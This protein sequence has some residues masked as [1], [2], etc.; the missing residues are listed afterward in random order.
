MKNR[1]FFI[2]LSFLFQSVLFAAPKNIESLSKADAKKLPSDRPSVAIV[3]A[4]GGAKGFAHLPIMEYLDEL[5]I[6]IDMIIGTSI[7]SIVGGFYAAGYSARDIVDEFSSVDWSPIFAD[8][9]RKPYED[10]YGIHGINA[11]PF[12]INMGTDFSLNMGTGLSNGQNVYQL[13]RSLLLKYPTDISFDNLPIPF[14]A[15]ATDMLTGEAYVLQDGDIADAMRASMSLPAVFE[16]VTIDDYYFMDGGLRYNLAINVAEKM[17]YDIIIG[18]DVS[19]HVRDDPELFSSNPAVAILNTITIAQY[20]TTEALLKDADL[21]IS[22]DISSYGTM[23]FKKANTIYNE[24]KEAVIK[25]KESL[26]EIRKLIYPDDY[27]E[28]GVRKSPYK[29]ISSESIY[30]SFGNL[31]PDT[32]TVDGAYK[33]DMKYIEKKFAKI[34]GKPL[35]QENFNEFMNDIYLT[36]NYASIRPRLV[37]ENGKNVLNLVLTKEE[38]KEVK[39]LIGTDFEQT[40]SKTTALTMNLELDLQ[41]RGLTGIGSMLSLHGTFLTDL[42]GELYYMQ[43]FNPYLF[44][45]ANAGYLQERYLRFADDKNINNGSDIKEYGLFYSSVNLGFR[46][47]GGNLI[48]LGGFFNIQNTSLLNY[49][50]DPDFYVYLDRTDYDD[51]GATLSYWGLKGVF[52]YSTLNS[53]AFPSEGI[54]INSDLRYIVPIKNNYSSKNSPLLT[55]RLNARFAL[56]LSKTLSLSM[57]GFFGTEFLGNMKEK[58]IIVSEEGFFPY[59]RI[60]FPSIQ[61]KRVFGSNAGA[62]AAYIQYKPNNHLTIFG[63]DLI[64]RLEGTAGFVNNDWKD[65]F[66]HIGDDNALYPVIWSGA[67]GAGIK[68]KPAFNILMRLGVSSTYEDKIVP[69]FCLDIG[70]FA[71]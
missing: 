10:V 6:P 69:M 25:H 48:T 51:Y 7:G 36:G 64:L 49:I 33:Q 24:G 18:I 41:V 1:K 26:E 39:L 65:T 15:V 34:K 30:K 70:D 28:N 44:L 9:A 11:N 57:R 63:G 35:A 37:S 14:R 42:G 46:T 27:D 47:I 29:T 54:S 3:L 71:F 50:Y 56:P 67:L 62:T 59:D 31:I 61:I 20:T 40:V 21:I 32:L 58:G 43:P 45:D 2:A 13:L 12:C 60:Y 19:Q 55:E 8:I 17:G 38:P 5:D 23:D 16:P 68:I 66:S 52:D 53:E 22:P 4:G